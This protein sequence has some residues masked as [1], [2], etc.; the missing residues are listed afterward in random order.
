MSD[1]LL[2]FKS[3]EN[4]RDFGGYATPSGTLRRGVLYRSGQLSRTSE[5]DLARVSQ[6][7][8]SHVVDL[9]RSSERKKQPDRLPQDWGGRVLATDLGGDGEAPHI[10]FLKTQELTEDSGRNYMGRTYERMPFDPGHVALF[11]GYFEA[12]AKG[13]GAVLI[14]CAAG[15]DRTGL[16]AALTHEALGVNED[17]IMADY[18][19]TNIAVD[20]EGRAEEFGH[21]LSKWT[22]KPVS[23]GAIVA[24][25]GVEA[26][27]LYRARH[28]MVE[29][30][31]SVEHYLAEVLN[32]DTAKR[33]AI[34]RHLSE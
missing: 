9:R 24:F 14:H 18:L 27:F 26:D 17:D 22:G 33:D 16:L 1:R 20:L 25:L 29:R 12:I 15:K 5:A 19:A 32:V 23:H 6:L 31:G 7:G 10:Q 11:Q 2:P 21:I 3:I 34:I 8:L 13:E 4:F 30:H 28:A